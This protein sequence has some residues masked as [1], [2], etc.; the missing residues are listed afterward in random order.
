VSI[1]DAHCGNKLDL[2]DKMPS[3]TVMFGAVAIASS[4]LET[5]DE[6]VARLRLAL[7]HIDRD[8]LVVAP[9]CGLGLLPAILAEA[10]LTV[11][12]EAARMV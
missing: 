7:D 4:R 12:C 1:E 5:V 11:M 10:K 9:D 6:V 8:R 2:L 3:K